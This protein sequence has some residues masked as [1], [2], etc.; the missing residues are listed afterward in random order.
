[1]SDLFGVRWCKAFDTFKDHDTFPKFHI[2]ICYLLADMKNQNTPNYLS[3]IY[4]GDL[5]PQTST[6]VSAMKQKM[7][8]S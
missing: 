3:F 1:M 7:K 6:E 8:R 5:Q 4:T 2:K